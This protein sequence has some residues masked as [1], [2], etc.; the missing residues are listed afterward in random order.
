MSRFPITLNTH[1]HTLDPALLSVL[2]RT[3]HL[4]ENRHIF[5]G[6]FVALLLFEYDRNISYSYFFGH[7]YEHLILLVWFYVGV[8]VC[9]INFNQNLYYILK[10]HVSDEIV[11]YK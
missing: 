10:L 3:P 7:L 11:S 4:F 5:C 6:L 8:M 2:S 1:N 9:N